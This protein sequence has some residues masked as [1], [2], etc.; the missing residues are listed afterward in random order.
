MVTTIYN[1]LF[2]LIILA[3]PLV[4]FGISVAGISLRF[5]R[6]LI[7]IILPIMVLKIMTKPSVV[8]RDKFLIF[9]ILPYMIYTT[10]SI[11]WT[12][13]VDVGAGFERL[14][15][16]YEIIILYT[17]LIVADLKAEK[18]IKF[19]KYYVLSALIPM[20][21]SVWQFANNILQ[22]S[23]SEVPFDIFLIEGK[24]EGLE[25]R[26]FSAGSGFSRLSATFAEPVIF[27][28]FICSVLLFSLLLKCNNY[29]LMI[30]LRLFQ[31]LAF[32][33]MVF[34]ISKL[35][36]LSF[37]VGFIFIIRKN[38]KYI[39]EF[40]AV[41]FILSTIVGLLY[42][43]DF[44]FLLERL[45]VDTGHYDLL[46]DSIINM[47]NINIL[48]GAGIGSIP[49]GSWHRFLLS[50]IYESGI[51]GLIFVFFV[52]VIPIKI[53]LLNMANYNSRNIKNVCVGV[54]IALLFGLHLYDYF[55]HLFPWIVIGAIMSFYNSEI[56]LNRLEL[57]QS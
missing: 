38:N 45:F 8:F 30:A 1:S 53:L 13:N 47:G 28:C 35:A 12:N 15:G 19:V 11:I 16:L 33:I 36:I 20:G 48:F 55:I 56:H 50:R 32:V 25:N 54:I 14:G 21:V 57:Q 44:N 37:L 18:F 31:I 27:S 43:Y 23:L 52:S 22:F 29:I 2:Y 5:S 39:I 24:Y 9:G 40:I 49:Y 34:S 51:F 46:I 26:F 17:I 42:Y 6:V 10:L 7:I 4:I 3:A 41:C